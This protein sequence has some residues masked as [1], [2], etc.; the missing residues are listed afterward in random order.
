MSEA[1]HEQMALP[2]HGTLCW[3]EIVTD[4]LE[5]ARNFYAEVFG[6]KINESENDAIEM[7][8]LE[9][10]TGTGQSSGGIYEINPEMCGGEAPPPHFMNYIAVDDVDASI[11]K[12][13]ELGGR[14]MGEPHDVPKV[15]R[16]AVV[17][18]PAGA[19]FALITFG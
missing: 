13:E 16:M 9:Y 6:W 15:G 4:D 18:D 11:K 5:K 12:V 7:K 19:T 10:D 17:S 3:T 8:Y 2:K 1:A 14:V